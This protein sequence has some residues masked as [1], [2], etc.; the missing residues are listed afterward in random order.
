MKDEEL[1]VLLKHLLDTHLMVDNGGLI[2]GKEQVINYI[3]SEMNDYK[4]EVM[5][6]L[7]GEKWVINLN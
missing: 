5:K 4:R 7:N 2:I 1:A 3:I 6:I